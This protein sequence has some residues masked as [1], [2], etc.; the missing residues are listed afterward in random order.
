MA[1]IFAGNQDCWS[2]L[3]KLINLS[4]S[5]LS[6]IPYVWPVVSQLASRLGLAG[7]KSILAQAEAGT[8]AELGSL[9]ISCFEA[10]VGRSLSMKVYHL[11]KRDLGLK[12]YYIGDQK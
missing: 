5:H 12:F 10:K 6:P 1:Q 8:G 3:N 7:T 11:Y 9:T 2:R 4:Y